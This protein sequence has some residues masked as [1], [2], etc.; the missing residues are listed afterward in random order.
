L[1]VTEVAVGV[2]DNTLISKLN[3]NVMPGDRWAIVGENGCG[4]STLLKALTG[5]LPELLMEGSIKVMPGV[6]LGYLEQTAVSGATTSVKSEVMSRMTEYQEALGELQ[7]SE[8]ACTSGSEC[9][10]ERL[11]AATGAFE[12]CGGYTVEARVGAVLKG[13]G[14]Q[15][16][17][18]DKP[19]DSFSGG[20]Q[21]RIALARLLL[22]EPELLV[23]DEP[24]NH[25]DA[26]AR[27][28]LGEYVGGYEGTVLLVSHDEAM[29]RRA[30]SSIAEVRGG[31]VEQYK[32]MGYDKFLVER[33][34][35]AKR[36]LAEYAALEKERDKMQ[37]FIDRMGAK[38]SKATQA[39]DRVKKLQKLEERMKLPA[40]VEAEGGRGPRLTLA[41]PPPCGQWPLELKDASFGYAKIPASAL[42]ASAG[43]AVNAGTSSAASA[44][45]GQE[46]EETVVVAAWHPSQCVVRGANLKIEKGMRVVIR[47]PN[48]AGKSTLLKALAG[49]LPLASAP[50]GRIEDERLSLGMFA[51]DL[52]QELPGNMAA[53]DYVCQSARQYDALLSDTEVRTIMG[54]LGL[55]GPKATRPIGTLSG[56]EKARVALATFCLTP[57]NVLLLDE[58]T[59]HLDVGAVACLLD[60]LERYP[61]TVLVVSHD[62]PFCEAV[63]CTHVA[64]VAHGKVNME[65]RSLNEAD[66]TVSEDTSAVNEGASTTT[67]AS[68]SRDPHEEEVALAFASLDVASLTI[69][70]V[71]G[72]KSSAGS[73]AEASLKTG[74]DMA[75]AAAEAFSVATASS[76][77][78]AN[79][80]LDAVEEKT[81]GGSHF[82]NDAPV[83]AM[84]MMAM[85]TTTEEEEEDTVGGAA[86]GRGGGG[87][88]HYSD[89]KAKKDMEKLEAETKRAKAAAAKAKPLNKK[90]AK[91]LYLEYEEIE[92]LVEATEA[93]AV[94]AA[95]ELLASKTLKP[96]LSFTE[97]SKLA[98]SASQARRTADEKFERY[99]ELEDLVQAH[100]ALAAA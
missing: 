20:W 27:R 21:M 13:L 64:F 48:G 81:V 95:D 53:V 45:S 14:F 66:W 74:A 41:K 25:L 42:A 73:V 18:Y 23:L 7:E 92:A 76:A 91:A 43:T 19:C 56:G 82:T 72:E 12:A 2:A 94:R 36:A 5:T 50:S 71:G 86:A 80:A 54:T 16:A 33:S 85:P 47:G 34:E 30:V 24:T 83:A 28:W 17:D 15:P 8:D 59:N 96:R 75:A 37:D 11:E 99:V 67:S 39:Q 97:Q 87:G 9:E 52:A 4:K 68:T 100:E 88:P 90:L 63:A 61:G 26:A 10:L 84:T 57:H 60:A 44:S 55:T 89:S 29:V 35:R 93:E 58:P 70:P 79:K 49:S 51:Q 3:W 98:A 22:S 6:R 1:S 38:A 46:E 69:T 31:E 78:R 77:A 32:S 40:F 62:R 65:E